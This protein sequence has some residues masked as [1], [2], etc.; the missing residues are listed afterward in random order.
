MVQKIHGFLMSK[1]ITVKYDF[2]VGFVFKSGSES[3][4]TEI[5]E[6]QDIVMQ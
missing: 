6:E 5:E 1:C 4:K 3:H 2:E